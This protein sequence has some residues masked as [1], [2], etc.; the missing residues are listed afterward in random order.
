MESRAAQVEEMPGQAM[1]VGSTISHYQLLEK[2]GGGA[3]GVIYEAVDTRLERLVALKLLAVTPGQSSD[4]PQGAPRHDSPAVE[5][6]RRA[7]R[8]ASALNHPNICVIHDVGQFEGQP[9]IVMELLEGNTLRRL[10]ETRPLQIDRVLDLA[11]HIVDALAA[12]HAKGIIHRDIK[13]GNV[14]VTTHGDAKIL[15]VVWPSLGRARTR[16]RSSQ[17][18]SRPRPS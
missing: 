15:E 10:I 11:I 12:A 8:A 18:P 1:T 14:F 2:T 4:S 13:P 5:P 6:F 16:W 9:F 3:M 17:W 7:A